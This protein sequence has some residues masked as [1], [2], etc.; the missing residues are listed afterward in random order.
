MSALHLTVRQY[1]RL[2]ASLPRGLFGPIW[3]GGCPPAIFIVPESC[4]IANAALIAYT[5]GALAERGR[6]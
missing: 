5:A 1:E 2:K 4:A 3:P 6:N